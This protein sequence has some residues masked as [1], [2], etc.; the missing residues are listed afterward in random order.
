MMNRL[1][2]LPTM[3]I[4]N[5][6]NEYSPSTWDIRIHCEFDEEIEYGENYNV[7]I[8]FEIPIEMYN[9]YNNLEKFEFAIQQTAMENHTENRWVY[10]SDY[11]LQEYVADGEGNENVVAFVEPRE[12][13]TDES[14]YNGVE[15]EALDNGSIEYIVNFEYVVYDVYSNEDDEWNDVINTIQWHTAENMSRF[16]HEF[17]PNPGQPNHIPPNQYGFAR[18]KV[19]ND[20]CFRADWWRQL[21]NN[22]IPS[23]LPVQNNT[24]V[25]VMGN[26][27]VNEKPT[28]KF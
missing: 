9:R 27:I 7:Y 4:Q 2:T 14:H 24:A 1:N 6:I 28:L 5:K 15:R 22:E 12:P 25:N 16:C 17:L 19:K 8:R 11:L 20:E 10:G 23:V 3:V 13:L 18:W 26:W 21:F